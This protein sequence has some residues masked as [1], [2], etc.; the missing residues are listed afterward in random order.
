MLEAYFLLVRVVVG[1]MILREFRGPPNRR[2]DVQRRN[3]VGW[4]KRILSYE[5]NT[6]PM[7]FLIK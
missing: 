4:I 6:K 7:G 5:K 2:F 1:G 3:I